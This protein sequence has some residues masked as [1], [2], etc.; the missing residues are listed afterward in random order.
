MLNK[1]QYSLT[2]IFA[3][4]IVACSTVQTVAPTY[5]FSDASKSIRVVLYD[6]RVIRF[7]EGD[8]TVSDKAD[9]TFLSGT[10]V[11]YTKT[12][13][14]QHKFEGRIGFREI[15]EMQIIEPASKWQTT[16][17]IIVGSLIVAFIIAISTLNFHT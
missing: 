5:L 2:F 15:K 11:Q 1:F 14:R 6:N 4:C 9:S 13:E 12:N 3:S 10:G 16:P 7:S 17:L 8:Y